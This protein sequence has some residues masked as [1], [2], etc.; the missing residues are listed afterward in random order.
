MAR[1]RKITPIEERISKAELKVQKA[2]KEYEAACAE[3]KELYAERNR[4]QADILLKAMAKK[5]KSF[6]EILRLIEL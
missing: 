2:G 6:E 5:G 4:I 3:L 1:P